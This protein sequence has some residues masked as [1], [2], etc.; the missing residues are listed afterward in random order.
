MGSKEWEARNDAK[1]WVN[2]DLLQVEI[3]ANGQMSEVRVYTLDGK[4]IH[5]IETRN[6]IAE[7]YLDKNGMYIV[8]V[9]QGSDR[10]TTKVVK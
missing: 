6:E 1:A 7:F 5:S 8:E 3:P 2:G 9:I 4:L 10:L